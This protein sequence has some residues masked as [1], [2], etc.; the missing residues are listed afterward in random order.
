MFT[1][2]G[3][4]HTSRESSMFQIAVIPSLA[5]TVILDVVPFTV[6]PNVTNGRDTLWQTQTVSVTL[7]GN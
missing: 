5:S 2:K 3:V 1:C 6:T 4:R 7:S